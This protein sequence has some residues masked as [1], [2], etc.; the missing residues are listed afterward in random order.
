[1]QSG[2]AGFDVISGLHAFS[3][4]A[5]L[6]NIHK[7]QTTNHKHLTLRSFPLHVLPMLQ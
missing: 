7:P 4:E 5:R 3:G 2:V 6:T 1:L